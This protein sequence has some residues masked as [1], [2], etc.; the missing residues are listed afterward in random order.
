MSSKKIW[1]NNFDNLKIYLKNS[2]SY[3]F[4]CGFLHKKKKNLN[5]N[6]F[7]QHTRN[8]L[9]SRKFLQLSC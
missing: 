8:L 2:Y 6:R 9:N 7:K 5:L 4:I 3:I 1:Q